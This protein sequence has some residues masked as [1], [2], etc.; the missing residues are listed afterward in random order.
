MISTPVPLVVCKSLNELKRFTDLKEITT[1]P[2]GRGCRAN[3]GKFMH[4]SFSRERSFG[5]VS[6]FVF[7][8]NKHEVRRESLEVGYYDDKRFREFIRLVIH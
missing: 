3:P 7:L 1:F 8:L 5:R 2:S 6:A 4:G